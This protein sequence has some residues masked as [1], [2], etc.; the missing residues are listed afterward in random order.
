MGGKWHSPREKWNFRVSFE[1]LY[2]EFIIDF[3]DASWTC[4]IDCLAGAECRV[5]LDRDT[6]A[7]TSHF[8]TSR[9]KE[10]HVP[11]CGQARSPARRHLY[12]CTIA[13]CIRF[14]AVAVFVSSSPF[15]GPSLLHAIRR[16]AFEHNQHGDFISIGIYVNQGRPCICG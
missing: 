4:V 6:I 11:S 15:L 7:T 2:P 1:K 3:R 10:G 9:S 13:L 14:S 8:L 16:T 5:T 12:C